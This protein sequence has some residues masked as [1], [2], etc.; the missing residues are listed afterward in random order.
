MIV[1]QTAAEACAAPPLRSGRVS[2][3]LSAALAN[4]RR[5]HG[6]KESRPTPIILPGQRSLAMDFRPGLPT[7][8]YQSSA[9]ASIRPTALSA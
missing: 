6:N 9:F 4:Y 8:P 1:Q 7:V 5:L 3:T 2:E